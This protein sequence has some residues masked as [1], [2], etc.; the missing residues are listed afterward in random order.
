MNEI[1]AILIPLLIQVESAGNPLAQ[2]DFN[3]SGPQAIGCLQIW[4]PYW[5]D[6]TQ[7]LGVDWEYKD[8]YNP[9]RAIAVTKAYLKRYGRNYRRQTGSDPSMEVLARIHNGGPQGWNPKNKDKYN[10][11]TH[12]W[13][14]VLKVQRLQKEEE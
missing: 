6:G 1:I 12:Y 8:A 5:I 2:G 4:E 10:R 13:K 9:D 3:K 14:K 7:E 11:T